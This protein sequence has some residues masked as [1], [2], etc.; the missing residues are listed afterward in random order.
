MKRSDVINSLIELP[1]NRRYLEIGVNRG[2]TFHSVSANRK[3][4]VDPEFLFDIDV[5]RRENLNSEYHEI[6]S[7]V[8]F[9]NM[10]LPSEVFDIIFLDGLHTFEQTLRDFNN[11]QWVLSDDGIIIIDDVVPSSFL[12]AMRDIQKWQQMRS[13]LNIEDK[14]WMGDVYKLVFYIAAYVPEFSFATVAD[15]HGQAVVWRQKR[16]HNPLNDGLIEPL[17]RMNYDDF[18]LH[19][20]A[21]RRMPLSNIIDEIKM[22]REHR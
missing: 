11:A 1:K 17:V 7:D 4:A 13:S 14:S 3:V 15:N 8:Y 5:A 2:E 10:I 16:A 12:S 22:C 18:I 6:T 19:K 9:E 21:M 20:S